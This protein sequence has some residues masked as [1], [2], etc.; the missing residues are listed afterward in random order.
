MAM[1]T[2]HVTGLAISYWHDS[3]TVSGFTNFSLLLSKDANTVVTTFIHGVPKTWLSSPVQ[4][5][6]VP[7]CTYWSLCITVHT[8][9]V[10]VSHCVRHCFLLCLVSCLV[11][12]CYA[13]IK[14]LLTYRLHCCT[15]VLLCKFIGNF[16][17]SPMHALYCHHHHHTHNCIIPQ[18]LALWLY[19]YGNSGCQR[20][21]EINSLKERKIL[22]SNTRYVKKYT[23]QMYSVSPKNPPPVVF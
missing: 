12:I 18:S 17:L 19:P 3:T 22:H 4:S 13:T 8:L 2:W 10:T 11:C 14:G 6:N 15:V 20:V 7:F 1:W 21:K 9:R 23:A 5:G 16:S